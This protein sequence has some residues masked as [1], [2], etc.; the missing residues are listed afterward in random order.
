MSKLFKNSL[1]FLIL[2]SLL[3]SIFVVF[4][5]SS[6]AETTQ[7][8][9]VKY[10]NVDG[11]LIEDEAQNPYHLYA[12]NTQLLDTKPSAYEQTQIDAGNILKYYYATNLIPLTYDENNPVEFEQLVKNNLNIVVVVQKAYVLE[13]YNFDEVKNEVDNVNYDKFI[14]EEPYTINNNPNITIGE[15]L[16]FY[17]Y[18]SETKQR[19]NKLEDSEL[20]NPI[21]ETYYYMALIRL[22]EYTIKFYVEGENNPFK[23]I[24]ITNLDENVTFPNDEAPPISGKKLQSWKSETSTEITAINP[25][26][27]RQSA[28]YY[29]HYETVYNITLV[30]DE[31]INGITKTDYE[32]SSIIDVYND[33][34]NTTKQGYNI[35]TKYQNTLIIA[36]SNFYTQFYNLEIIDENTETEIIDFTLNV[37]LDIQYYVISINYQLGS[38]E[39]GAEEVKTQFSLKDLNTSITLPTLTRPGYNFVGYYLN[40]DTLETPLENNTYTLTE[41]KNIGFTAIFNPKEYTITLIDQKNNT[42]EQVSVIF[43]QDCSNLTEP[44]KEGYTFVCWQDSNNKEYSKNT[45]Y[46]NV[47]DIELYAKYNPITCKITLNLNYAGQQKS[48]VQVKYDAVPS[49]LT[50]QRLGYSFVEWQYKNAKFD[51][52]KAYKEIENIEIVAVWKPNNYLITIFVKDKEFKKQATY[53]SACNILDEEM[54]N[55]MNFIIGFY[56]ESENYFVGKSGFI[57]KYNFANDITLYAKDFAPYDFNDVILNEINFNTKN[58]FDAKLLINGEQKDISSEEDIYKI[59]KIGNYNIKLY[60]S[61]SKV[62]EIDFVLDADLGIENNKNYNE[63][64]TL[65]KVDAQ[66][67]VDGKLIENNNYR[68]TK[69][70]KHTIKVVGVNGYEKTYSVSYKNNNILY[71]IIMSAIAFAFAIGAGFMLFSG[72]KNVIKYDSNN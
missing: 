1:Y 35:H 9:T 48:E 7:Q 27:V 12:E 32:N 46:T 43:N 64:I 63:P 67:Y 61:S 62:Y 65:N 30:V 26:F 29:A 20:N 38:T 31:N 4:Q 59:T 10:Y 40:E 55:H 17:H 15:G 19:G 33:I 18:F 72:R 56:S 70:G 68:I 28:N 60:I 14:F 51:T 5:V 53:D 49:I 71:A 50:P 39:E 58:L 2:L 45:A 6:F 21:D 54:K 42:R 3:A 16:H 11:E 52:T 37:S 69:N 44:Q 23:T 22:K 24:T 34:K 36:N 41:L 25:K 57:N 47:G 8:F 66:I 13:I